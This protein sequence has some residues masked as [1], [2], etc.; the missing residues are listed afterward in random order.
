MQCFVVSPLSIYSIII[1]ALFEIH[2]RWNVNFDTHFCY[3]KIQRRSWIRFFYTYTSNLLIIA[4]KAFFIKKKYTQTTDILQLLKRSKATFGGSDP[5]SIPHF[6]LWTVVGRASG[7]MINPYAAAAVQTQL[8][9]VE[10][11]ESSIMRP[12]IHHN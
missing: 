10:R 4:C 3:Q 12:N 2:W 9:N 6:Y 7:W 5:Y 1:A 11:T 8:R